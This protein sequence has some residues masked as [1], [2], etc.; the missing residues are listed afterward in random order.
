MHAPPIDVRYNASRMSFSIKKVSSEPSRRH[1]AWQ[2]LCLFALKWGRP[3][4]H[5][6]W[7]WKERKEQQK[8]K[9]K[10]MMLLKRSLL[11]V[12]S[13]LCG[14]LLLG[15]VLRMLLHVRILSLTD[16]LVIPGVELPKDEDGFTNFLLLGE[17]DVT[18]EYLTDSVLVASLDP[19]TESVVLLTL[20]RDLYLLNTE[21]IE[22]GRINSR[23]R[24]EGYRAR[25]RGEESVTLSR[26]AMKAVA[27]EV[28]KA[29]NLPLHHVV[30]VNFDGFVQAVDALGGI[31][32]T[33]PEAIKDEEYPG[34]NYTYETF[35]IPAGNQHLNGTTV[36]KYAR[37]RSTTS[38]FDRSK[39][40]QQILKAIGVKIQEEGLLRRPEKL[41]SLLPIA[42]RNTEMT[43]STGEIMTLAK[44]GLSIPTER[45]LTLQLH[46]RNGLYG[47]VLEAGGFLYTPP[48]NLFDGASVLLPISFPE[49]PV[50]WKQP[51]NLVRLLTQNREIYLRH[52]TLSI[53]NAGAPTGHARKLGNELTRYGFAVHNIANAPPPKHETSSITPRSLNETNLAEFF[54]TLLKIPLTPPKETGTPLPSVSDVTIM[55][56]KDFRFTPLQNLQPISQ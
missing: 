20:P 26:E 14:L 25:R 44:L 30:K 17:G 29:L 42:A 39:R 41:L 32:M 53:F 9:G 2:A 18:G 56:G 40:Q 36:L 3:I 13:I 43:L 15:G 31:E 1:I 4:L 33:I 47:E 8:K 21:F 34:P 46:D 38:D 37:S 11:I 35:D 5:W 24:D 6:Y 52:P 23:Y 28:G 51:Q 27:A 16:F 48:R 49:F 50:T 54:G 19:K 22:P 55:V 45:V 12:I 10:R 7:D